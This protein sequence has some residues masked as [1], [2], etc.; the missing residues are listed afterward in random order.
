MDIE[1]IDTQNDSTKHL[2]QMISY[3][4]YCLLNYSKQKKKDISP[5]EDKVV[6]SCDFYIQ[7]QIKTSIKGHLIKYI[8][9]YSVRIYIIYI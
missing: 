3:F 1:K 6:E 7:K 8:F 2:F 4:S 5:H 9:F